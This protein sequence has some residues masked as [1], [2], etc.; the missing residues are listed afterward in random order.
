MHRPR[1]PQIIVDSNDNCKE[2][3]KDEGNDDRREDRFRDDRSEKSDRDRIS[4]LTTVSSTN[5]MSELLQAPDKRHSRPK[6]FSRA[7]QY[8]GKSP[9]L[10]FSNSFEFTE[11]KAER[12]LEHDAKLEAIISSITSSINNGINKPLSVQTQGPLLRVF[13]A[14]RLLVDEKGDLGRKLAEAVSHNN[15]TLDTLE[16]ERRRWKEDELNYK[17]E[18]KRLE[19]IIANGKIGLAEVALARQTSLI[20]RGARPAARDGSSGESG[21]SDVTV[22]NRAV[23]PLS[24]SHAMSVLSRSFSRSQLQRA[25]F[26]QADLP[27]GTPPSGREKVGL[28][29]SNIS[30][31]RHW[32]KD[33]DTTSWSK[34]IPSTRSEYG[35]SENPDDDLYS[36]FSSNG[37]DLLEDEIDQKNLTAQAIEHVAKLIAD[38]RNSPVEMTVAWLHRCMTAHIESIGEGPPSSTS[39]SSY[40]DSS[41]DRYHKTQHTQ[42]REQLSMR[43]RG[44]KMEIETEKKE[45]LRPFS[46]FAGDDNDNDMVIRSAP[47]E[48]TT[49][50]DAQFSPVMLTG[51]S[52]SMIPSPVSEHLLAH[53]R[54]EDSASSLVTSLHRSPCSESALP[55]TP[56]GSSSHLS[57]ATA[58]R[59][60]PGGFS[61]VDGLNNMRNSS[62]SGSRE[63]RSPTMSNRSSI[64]DSLSNMREGN[65]SG[66]RKYRSPT[67][68][69]RSSVY[70]PPDSADDE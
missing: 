1:T 9:N 69:N 13:E 42:I 19:V 18:I 8:F 31:P 40:P 25:P 38:A 54:R 7:S 46:F 30:M 63:Y 35:Y 70:I 4:S 37:G 62:G 11:V 52:Q 59:Q 16:G 22:V 2:N 24:P 49:V 64:V 48:T 47:P 27:P 23:R 43:R 68:S 10:R 45:T 32:A 55:R 58:L 36:D 51:R 15:T 29:L 20:R 44:E 65:G 53:P 56:S 17:A 67:T 39:D 61:I 34:S 41:F 66:S 3:R 33:S 5:S 60:R 50:Y 26:V 12:N 14:Y 57:V 21:G 6:L 28:G